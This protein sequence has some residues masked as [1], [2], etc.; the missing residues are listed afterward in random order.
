[1]T[2]KPNKKYVHGPFA[3][4]GRVITCEVCGHQHRSTYCVV[5]ETTGDNGD[6]VDE[7]T[8]NKDDTRDT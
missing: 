8:K 1:M 6:W 3:V 5:C 7:V 2:L 4:P